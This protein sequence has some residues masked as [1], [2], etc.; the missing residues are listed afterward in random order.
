MVIASIQRS[1]LISK[2]ENGEL[3]AQ[4]QLAEIYRTGDGVDANITEAVKYYSMAAR[5]NHPG[6][7]FFIAECQDMGRG[8]PA[9]PEY[10]FQNYL[11]AAKLGHPEACVSVG[12]FYEVGRATYQNKGL[13][14]EYY[15]LAAAKGNANGAKKLAALGGADTVN[16]K[17]STQSSS[18]SPLDRALIDRNADEVD[19]NKLGELR[20]L[21]VDVVSRCEDPKKLETI[22]KALR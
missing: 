6:A 22:I 3:D 18:T 12:Y 7:L 20:K 8:M 15:Q 13:A 10:A 9:N 21:A 11:K 4:L 1:R 16:G 19:R 14:R 2:A 5:H 17:A